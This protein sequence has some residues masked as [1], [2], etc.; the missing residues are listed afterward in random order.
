MLPLAVNTLAA[1][2][3]AYS[4]ALGLGVILGTS[5]A[6]VVCAAIP[7]TTGIT[8][9]HVTLGIVFGLITVPIATLLGCFGGLP[10]A[11]VFS[12]IIT[13]LPVPNKPLLSHAEVEAE[14][15]RARGY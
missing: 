1:L 9:G 8:K 13:L 14:M 12:L 4:T 15:R 6:V 2:P 10:V 5:I 3:F 11:C 7:L